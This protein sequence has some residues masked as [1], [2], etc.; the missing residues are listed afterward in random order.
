MTNYHRQKIVQIILNVIAFAI[1]WFISSFFDN[2]F[3]V[4][5]VTYSAI[6]ICSIPLELFILKKW[7]KDSQ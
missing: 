6:Y 7:N 3:I 5:L 1:A 4:L 2:N